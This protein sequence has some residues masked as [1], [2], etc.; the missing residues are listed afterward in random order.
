MAG[1]GDILSGAAGHPVDRLGLQS[2]VANSQA[3][4]GLRSAQ[5]EEAM[6]NA[7]KMT[8][9]SQAQGQM[10]DALVADGHPQSEAHL[11]STISRGMLGD[12]F[13]H[14]VK[15][16]GDQQQQGFHGTL[17]DPSQLGSAAQTAAQ[18][19]VTGRVAEPVALPNNFTTLPGAAPVDARQSLEGKAQSASENAEATLRNAQAAAGG[20]NPH[21]MNSVGTLSP[22]L[23]SAVDEGRLD[24][25]RLNSR[26]VQI[27]DQLA[28]NNGSYNFNQ[29]HAD[30]SLN[31]NN[32]FRQ[33]AMTL[34]ALPGIMSNMTSL[35]KKVGYSDNRVV[36]S[37][38]QWFKGLNNDPDLTEYMTVR[39]D[40]L[41][42]IASAMRGV[43]MSDQAHT[44]EIEAANPTL[45]PMA[46]D[47]WLK[48]QMS[49]LQPRLDKIKQV[50]HIGQDGSA[51]PGGTS[52][53]M[54]ASATPPPTAVPASYASEAEALAAGHKIGDRV[55]IGG[56]SGTLQ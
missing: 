26:T 1:I 17:G 37:M 7:Q 24:P 47:S 46:L 31:A 15:G 33:K 48:G 3:M 13:E 38:Q 4:N 49:T 52:P 40:A 53:P 8:E 27:Y 51:E 43:G 20:F 54:P 11:I 35:G 39:N 36:G 2:F 30:A 32:Q 5:T 42:N 41:M 10:E 23:Q 56:R 21:S 16:I 18:Q 14:V 28:Q 55:T 34:E 9:Q 6:A 19:G 25:A 22:A 50:T 12:Q 29:Q 44:A 45:S